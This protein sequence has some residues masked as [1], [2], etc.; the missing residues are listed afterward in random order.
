MLHQG[1][2]RDFVSAECNGVSK[3][4]AFITPYANDEHFQDH[5]LG[6]LNNIAFGEASLSALQLSDSDL[7]TILQMVL[8]QPND[9]VR[10]NY[11]FAFIWKLSCDHVQAPKLWRHLFQRLPTTR[12]QEI[13]RALP[14]ARAINA[15]SY[16]THLKNSV[17]EV[18]VTLNAIIEQ[19]T[20]VTPAFPGRLTRFAEQLL[21]AIMDILCQLLLKSDTKHQA[22]EALEKFGSVLESQQKGL[23]KRLKTSA[24][25]C[26]FLSEYMDNLRDGTSKHP[27]SGFEAVQGSFFVKVS[28]DGTECRND[29]ESF[30]SAIWRTPVRKGRFFYEIQLATG[31]IM[32]I[33]W[34]SNLAK[35]A[36]QLGVGVGDEEHSYSS[37]YFPFCFFSPIELLL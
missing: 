6:L 33:G 32:Q 14:F 12:L 9:S 30:E 31:D 36:S 21:C 28:A 3:L 35:L 27:E 37:S 7:A 23:A 5:F 20:P 24:S 25:T 34:A 18:L 4:A 16:G 22:L 15:F 1:F 26:G 2:L 19:M 11:G 10:A 13:R 29:C 8:S 17:T